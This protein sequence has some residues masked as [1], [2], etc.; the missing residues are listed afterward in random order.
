MRNIRTAILVFLCLGLFAPGSFPTAAAEEPDGPKLFIDSFRPAV[1]G[2]KA[3]LTVTGRLANSSANPIALPAVQLRFS[4]T[5]LTARPE[6][7]QVLDGTS[8]RTGLPLTSTLTS[9]GEILQPGQQLSFRLEVPIADLNLTE[10][11]AVF[12]IFVEALS[13]TAAITSTGTVF[14]WFPETAEF[15]KSRLAMLWPVTQYPA[16]AAERLVVGEVVL[17]DY[18]VGG[19]L[20]QLVTA[21]SKS[22]VSWLIDSSTAQS[23]KKLSSGYVT[24]GPD[25]LE[26]GDATEAAGRMSRQLSAILENEKNVAVP[27]FAIADAD[28]L[29]DNDLDSN[30]VRAISLPRV[31]ISGQAPDA[32]PTAVFEAPGSLNRP[33]A[34]AAVADSGLRVA[35]M[36]DELFPPT[37]PLPYTPSGLA[38]INAGGTSLEVLLTDSQLD[39]YLELSLANQSIRTTA[40]QGFL[41]ETAMITLERPLSPRTVASMPPLLWDPPLAWTESLL[42]K[43]KKASWLKLVGLDEVL[44]SETVPRNATWES[45]RPT[46]AQLPK[47]YMR[48]VEQ[49]QRDLDGLISIITDPEGFGESFQLAIQRASSSL[50]RGQPRQRDQLVSTIEAQ[51]ATARDSV[52]VLTNSGVIT[53]AGD[54]GNLPLTVTNELDRSVTVQVDLATESSISVDYAAPEP[55]TIEPKGK[56]SLEIPVRVLG[57]Q[58]VDVQVVLSD[59]NGE[60]YSDAATL[61]LRSTAA[62]QIAGVIVGIGGAALIVL[63]A[64]NLWRRHRTRE[65]SDDGSK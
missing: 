18:E 43:L 22:D 57:T 61:Q 6:I 48:R 64:L 8:P 46:K 1:P 12:A 16:I 40:M 17:A 9:L 11:G 3:N 28:A 5:P 50:W 58:P 39:S 14:P 31:I 54:T 4:P 38:R 33:K 62:T 15:K 25:G 44:G 26:P 42:K 29:I 65:V 32:D 60:L 34:M 19:R 7:S 20:E 24:R 56:A 41:A 2:P 36:S 59:K 55:I 35:V 37:P 45:A 47:D 13:G 30:L 10:S 23:A 27:Q 51:L 53:L 49:L 21:G 63:V 52:R